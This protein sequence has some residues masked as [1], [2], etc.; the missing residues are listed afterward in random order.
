MDMPQS[1]QTS[2]DA[3]QVI[4]GVFLTPRV[5]DQR[6]F[7]EYSASLKELI[8]EASGRGQALRAAVGDVKVLGD[9]LRQATKEITGRLET[10]VKVMPTLEQRLGKAEQVLQLASDRTRLAEHLERTLEGLISEKLA[11]AE[12]RIGLMFEGLEKR[13]DDARKAKEERIN[14][15]VAVF[16]S[17]IQTRMA[18]WQDRLTAQRDRALFDAQA[19]GAKAREEVLSAASELT[20]KVREAATL[21]ESVG[22]ETDAAQSRLTVLARSCEERLKG[23]ALTATR[24]AESAQEQ[25]ELAATQAGEHVAGAEARVAQATRGIEERLAPL[26]DRAEKAREELHD[27]VTKVAWDL[28]ASTGPHLAKLERLCDRAESLGSHLGRAGADESGTLSSMFEKVEALRADVERATA[29]LDAARSQADAA[30]AALGNA[31]QQALARLE[32]VER[33]AGDASTRADSLSGSLTAA[34]KAQEETS[35]RLADTIALARQALGMIDAA[36]SS[37]TPVSEIEPAGDPEP[38]RAV[39]DVMGRLKAELAR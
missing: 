3:D 16:E 14:A 15:L 38:S 21:R 13:L 7:E 12:K 35:R 29:R 5:V 36:R 30:H 8:R 27:R 28:Q 22:K 34:Q 32:E 20:S 25:L 23:A 9:N 6:A 17:Q 11:S 19:A 26:C 39:R 31:T 2:P 24:R 18:D 37:L 1:L 33:R 4:D 10:A